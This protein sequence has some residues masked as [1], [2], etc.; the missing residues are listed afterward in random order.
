MLLNWR[1]QYL[2]QRCQETDEGTVV[3]VSDGILAHFLETFLKERMSST[4][5]NANT[6]KSKKQFVIPT[7]VDADRLI[8]KQTWKS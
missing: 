4:V 3:L 2:E 8:P 1:I 7:I 6:R 5:R